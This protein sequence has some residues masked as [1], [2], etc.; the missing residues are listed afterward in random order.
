MIFSRLM[1]AIE[2]IRKKLGF[3]KY[4]LSKELGISQTQYNYYVKNPASIKLP[5]LSKLK[6]ISGLSWTDIGE[7]ID[8]SQRRK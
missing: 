5:M 7:L 1:E 8:K 4:K 6:E 3:S 2:K